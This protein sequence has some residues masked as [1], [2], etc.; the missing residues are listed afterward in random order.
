VKGPTLKGKFFLHLHISF[1]HPTNEK[2][3]ILPFSIC[4]IRNDFSI[5]KKKW[6]SNLKVFL[7]SNIETK[8]FISMKRRAKIMAMQEKLS[9]CKMLRRLAAVRFRV[10]ILLLHLYF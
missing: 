6:L 10:W 1:S 3:F 2:I 4:P 7:A 8:F 5:Y 9:F